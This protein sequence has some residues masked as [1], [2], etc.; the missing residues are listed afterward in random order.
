MVNLRALWMVDGLAGLFVGTI[1][2]EMVTFPGFSH[3]DY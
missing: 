1:I 2:A 3:A